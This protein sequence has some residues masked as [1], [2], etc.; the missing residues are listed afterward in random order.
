[1]CGAQLRGVGRSYQPGEAAA[2]VGGAEGAPEAGA[3]GGRRGA[4]VKEL[5]AEAGQLGGAVGGAGDG[6]GA[7]ASRVWQ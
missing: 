4:E 5:G 2:E 1:V 3:P 7:A 6:R